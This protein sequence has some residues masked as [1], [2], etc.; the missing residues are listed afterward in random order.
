[1]VQNWRKVGSA[2]SG[3]ALGHPTPL[4]CGDGDAQGRASPD[5]AEGESCRPDAGTRRA[6]AAPDHPRRPH[7]S[8]SGVRMRHLTEASS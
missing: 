6:A 1:M 2:K 7:R 8:T 3:Y 5:V 4:G